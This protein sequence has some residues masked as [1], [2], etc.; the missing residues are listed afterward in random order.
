MPRS[1]W[2]KASRSSNPEPAK[3]AR[4]RLGPSHSLT[5][6]L[7]NERSFMEPFKFCPHCRKPL[8]P[9]IR[10]GRQYPACPACPFIHWNNP[11]PVV[12]I[13]IPM[14]HHLL[15]RAGITAIG[16]P[17]GG[18]V[19]ERRAI[20]PCTGEWCLP[21]G[22]V[23]EESDPESEAIRE[24]QDECGLIVRIERIITA[25]NPT[26]TRNKVML[27]FLGRPVGGTLHA[28]VE[29]L[30]VQVFGKDN[31]PEICFP[32]HQ[33]LVECWFKGSLGTLTGENLLL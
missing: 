22:Y 10:N 16:I 8:I 9:V 25:R 32:F 17:D 13:L 1:L 30:E 27:P 21:S 29:C 33:K 7:N 26:L 31:L 3:E 19:L 14:F 28:G 11:I 5:L 2:R 6:V 15:R 12:I 23:D 18:I 4:V 24:T 20:E